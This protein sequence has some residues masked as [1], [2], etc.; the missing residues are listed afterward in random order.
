MA[1]LIVLLAAVFAA[2]SNFFMRRTLDGG[3]TPQGFL[4]LQFGTS[5]ILNLAVCPQAIQ[6]IGRAGPVLGIGAVAGLCV[7]GMM[8]ATGRAL[9]SGPP[10]L[11]FAAL[12]AATVLPGPVMAILFGMA[13]GFDL[14]TAQMVGLFLVLLGLFWAARHERAP[15][16]WV[17]P[18]GVA[19][20]LHATL[21]VI[22]QWRCLLMRA[23]LP[24]HHLLPIRLDTSMEGWFLPGMFLAAFVAQI[25]FFGVTERRWPRTAEWING[26]AGGAANGAG[27]WCL[28]QGI[29]A[30]TGPE[31]VMIFP[32]FAIA[33]IAFT[34]GWSRWLY[35]EKVSWGATA[36]CGL[37]IL[38]GTVAWAR[39]GWLT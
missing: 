34:N 27:A 5:L 25:L 8:C 18:S 11:T 3:G 20:L 37:G 7:F 16:R 32:L 33:I 31:H 9:A 21:M 4:L 17:V 15:W 39:L 1:I 36:L 10:G 6:D 13:F 14:T 38:V 24:A 26:L 35:R 29:V 28:V 22:M 2:I 19:L 23:D 30:A 12:N